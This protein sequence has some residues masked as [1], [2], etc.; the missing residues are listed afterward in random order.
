MDT[1]I[2]QAESVAIRAW[3]EK[4]LIYLELTDGRIFGFRL[5]VF[6]FLVKRLK[7]SSRRFRLKWMDMH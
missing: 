5:T 3:A 1:I 2:P 4:R 6:A 7:I